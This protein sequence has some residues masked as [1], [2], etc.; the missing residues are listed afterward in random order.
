MRKQ[1][2]EAERKL[3]EILSEKQ[4]ARLK[5]LALQLQGP[6]ALLA[7]DAAKK[8]ELTEEQCEKIRRLSRK[9]EKSL[10]TILTDQQWKQWHEMIGQPFKGKI[11]LGP[12]G[13][14]P[15]RNGER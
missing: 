4:L 10:K 2:T 7:S 1:M 6:R 13:G 15:P 11:A 5:Q 12:P 9:N 14:P 3:A 8:L